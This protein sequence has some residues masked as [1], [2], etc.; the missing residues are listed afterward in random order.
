MGGGM[1]QGGIL[2]AGGLYALKHNIERLKD[3]N[4]RAKRI[5]EILSAQPYVESIHPIM[6][7]IV[8]FT[9]K[10]HTAAEFVTYLESNGV[11]ASAFGKQQVRF[12][13]HMDFKPEMMERLEKILS[14][15]PTLG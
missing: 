1:R 10:G 9:L 15:N 6:T 11:Q 3:D 13:T 12:V 4:D 2:A 5:G 14:Q 7:N 8:I